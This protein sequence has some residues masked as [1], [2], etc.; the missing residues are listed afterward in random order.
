[1]ITAA[2]IRIATMTPTIAQNSVVLNACFV[3]VL[4]R[5]ANPRASLLSGERPRA[6]LVAASIYES[7]LY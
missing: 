3:S 4:K 5:R 1:L 7:F 6:P 2:L